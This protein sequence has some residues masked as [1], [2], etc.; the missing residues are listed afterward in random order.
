M[1][2]EQITLNHLRMTLQSSFETSF[3]S[4]D[5]RDSLL[6]EV[7]AEGLT[8]LGECV[9]DYHPGY[10]YE[11]SGTAWHILEDFIIPALKGKTIEHP[12]DYYEPECLCFSDS[13]GCCNPTGCDAHGR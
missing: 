1:H 7:N 6:I 13:C 2:I 8:G 9:A 4:I 11:T 12:K 10:S 3:G 5:T